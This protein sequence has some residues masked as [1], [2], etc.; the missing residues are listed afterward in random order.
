M[1]SESRY[2]YRRPARLDDTLRIAVTGDA[3]P[4]CSVVARFDVKRD[5]DV[6][7]TAEITYIAVKAVTAAP[8]QH[9]CND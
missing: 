6:L 4:Q 2:R 8:S 7:A 3:A 5:Q 1:I 9:R